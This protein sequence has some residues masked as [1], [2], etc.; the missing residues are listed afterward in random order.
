MKFCTPNLPQKMVKKAFVSAII[1]DE[2]KENLKNLGI[3][4]FDAPV[5]SN[6][7]SELKYHPDIVLN[8][9]HKGVWYYTGDTI[10]S[11]LLTKGNTELSDKYPNDCA[12]NCFVVDGVLYG[13]KSAADEIKKYAEKHI[14]IAQ[15]YTKC[16][17]VI[18]SSESFI[19]SDASVY[20]ALVKEGK[21][22][23]S[24]CNGGILLNGYSCGFIGGCTG[25]LGSKILAVT[26]NAKLLEDYERIQVFCKNLGYDVIS[27]SKS[28]PYDYGG[29]LP[30][31]EED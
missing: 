2:I 26:G 14:V 8:N 18:L 9:P 17:T 10:D 6:L 23:L 28:Q 12:Y 13:G 24:V 27:L 7:N 19:T 1:S 16:S 11:D 30:I 3:E 22:V 29:I 25:V 21:N 31:C 4:C 5:C 20:K 15:G